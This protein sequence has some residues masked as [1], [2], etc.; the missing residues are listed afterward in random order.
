MTWEVMTACVIMHIIVE[1]SMMTSSM[2]KGGNFRVNWLQLLLDWHHFKK[3]LYAHH[4]IRD[5]A[6]H[7]QLQEDLVNHVWI[8]A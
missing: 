5:R 1:A 3:N 2:T 4:Q 7:N 8:H 6:T